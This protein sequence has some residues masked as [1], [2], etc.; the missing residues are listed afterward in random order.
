[1]ERLTKSSMDLS[2]ARELIDDSF[3]TP[4]VHV[5]YYS[6]FLIMKYVCNRFLSLSYSVQDDPQKGKTS[7]IDVYNKIKE[8]IPNDDKRTFKSLFNLLNR[9]RIKADYSVDSFDK[10]CAEE[11]FTTA[12]EFNRLLRKIYNF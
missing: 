3:F 9:N 6:S 5:S 11:T 7:H 12:S 8:I 1:M 10:I 4:S 2:A